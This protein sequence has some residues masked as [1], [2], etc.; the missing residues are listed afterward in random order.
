VVPVI[1]A[2][3]LVPRMLTVI[4]CGV[5]SAVVTVMLSV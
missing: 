2:A 5:P 3:S 4:T 1:V